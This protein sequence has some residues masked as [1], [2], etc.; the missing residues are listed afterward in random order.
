MKNNLGMPKKSAQIIK[1]ALKTKVKKRLAKKKAALS[2]RVGRIFDSAGNELDLVVFD[3]SLSDDFYHIPIASNSNLVKIKVVSHPLDQYSSPHLLNLAKSKYIE[4]VKP[5]YEKSDISYSDLPAG[6]FL[7]KIHL[8]ELL[9]L[10]NSEIW[11]FL[12]NSWKKSVYG[13]QKQ[14]H[15]FD[16]APK[17]PLAKK[18]AVA[19]QLGLWQEVSLINLM[20]YIFSK[21]NSLLAIIKEISDYFYELFFKPY[22]SRDEVINF[23]LPDRQDER[24][25]ISSPDLSDRPDYKIRPLNFS[26]KK[27]WPDFSWK[28]ISLKPLLVFLAGVLLITIP[29]KSYFY[30][31]DAKAAKG[32]VL[33]Q[34][35]EALS[36]LDLAQNALSSFNLSEAEKYLV[37]ANKDFISA[38]DQLSEIKSFLTVLA[39]TIP[40]NNTFKSG[41]NILDLGERL[42]KAGEYLIAGLN[43][44]SGES[45]FSLSSRIKNFKVN[46]DNALEQLQAAS[47]NLEKI[48]INHLPEDNQ[49]KF[50]ALNSNLPKFIKSL[51]KSS[52]IMQFA[53][54]FLGDKNLKKYLLVFQ[55]DNELR[56]SGGFMGSL[57]IVDFKNGNLANITI[58]PGGTYDLRA[59]LT[60]L[61]QAPEPLRLV[62]PQWEFQ[63]TNWWPSWPASASNI[64]YFY[65]KSDGATIDGV[66]AVNSDWLGKLLEVVGPIDLPDYQK[67]IT[68]ENFEME[69]QKSVEIEYTDKKQPKKILSDL[70]PK[71]LANILEASPDKMLSLASIFNQGLKEKD[72]QL[73]MINEDEE[74]FVLDNNWGGQMKEAQKDYLSVVATNIGGGKTDNVIKQEIYHQASIL[75]DGSVIDNLVIS[76]SHFGPIDDN[77][78][79]VPNRSFIRVY[80]PLGSQLLRAEGFKRPSD[81][82]FR[83][84]EKYLTE[85]DRLLNEKLAIT[86]DSSLTK[87]YAENNKTVFGNW[88][89][90][91]PG[92]TKEALLVYKLPFKINLSGQKELASNWLGKIKAAFSSSLA[93]DSY[94]LLVQK[95]AGSQDDKFVGQVEYPVGVLANIHYPNQVENNS[96]ESVYEN[97]LSQ[98]LFYFIGLQK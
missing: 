6:D 32:K 40:L 23:Q 30:L 48:N 36:R 5:A 45:D 11:R 85:D 46:N 95:Q 10:E 59:G 28:I 71:L 69:L 66:I 80:V 86:D 62:N 52:A 93:H 79:N 25:T 55:N 41:K 92:E 53:I 94:S 57:A 8:F 63:D 61:L 81:Q 29:I 51:E 44:F 24:E 64:A 90:V 7:E 16:F 97:K 88:L 26:G 70:A 13:I 34:A 91:K 15:R 4:R 82:E 76:R 27:I 47:G 31:Q 54:D 35:E 74:K 20:I 18:K 87:I 89:T 22:L 56:A 58:P 98:D 73:Y 42:T 77:F 37:A 78:T 38:Q 84:P 9:S 17:L 65:N 75:A 49:E 43:E 12:K 83:Q 67:T 39:E 21:I 50:A 60:K 72:I 3:H 19:K 14:F 1:K 96:Q 68:A 2:K 33:G